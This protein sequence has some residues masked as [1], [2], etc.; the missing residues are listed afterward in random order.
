M[1]KAK[2][3]RVKQHRMAIMSLRAWGTTDPDRAKAARA[4]VMIEEHEAA[5][6]ELGDVQA[7]G[8]V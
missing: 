7:L 3:K 8:R 1:S 4:W 6:R 2:L 5:I